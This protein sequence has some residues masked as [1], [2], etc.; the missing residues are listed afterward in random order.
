[1]KDR[2][3]YGSTRST[4][5]EGPYEPETG[6]YGDTIASSAD[7]ILESLVGAMF[8]AVVYLDDSLYIK[9]DSSRL[10]AFIEDGLSESIEGKPFIDLISDPDD[11][12]R[13][14][15]F[16][17]AISGTTASQIELSLVGSNCRLYI[18]RT[19]AGSSNLFVGIQVL[20]TPPAPPA[21]PPR[22]APTVF[23]Q[24]YRTPSLIEAVES[25]YGGYNSNCRQFPGVS[26][27][28]D[29]APPP[30]VSL[31]AVFYR[32][33][34]ND[35]VHMA[36]SAELESH[37]KAEVG[38]LT[39]HYQPP[40]IDALVEDLVRLL[41]N[42]KQLEFLEAVTRHDMFQVCSL[43]QQT[44]LG[45]LNMLSFSSGL[46]PTSSVQHV[47]AASRLILGHL[48]QMEET[49]LIPFFDKWI[50]GYDS[51][52]MFC[53]SMRAKIGLTM[54]SC[55]IRHPV[56][57][58]SPEERQ[59]LS[60][61]FS[62]LIST[63][64]SFGITDSVR[65]LAVYSACMLWARYQLDQGPQGSATASNLLEACMK[66]MDIFS[67]RHPGSV[68]VPKLRAMACFN[69][70]SVALNQRDFEKASVW[71]SEL[72]SISEKNFE[73]K[74]AF[75]LSKF[76]TYPMILSAKKTAKESDKLPVFMTDY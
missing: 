7:F 65:L 76:D 8:D 37:P 18:S 58:D 38:W 30:S 66:D 71:V 47:C 20:G 75:W 68:L 6:S 2:E 70:A 4:I 9:A 32:A 49:A 57:F 56:I 13:F 52:N 45:N 31:V 35:L 36:S 27:G 24:E 22:L 33:L 59:R 63:T 62:K 41:P 12:E 73:E 17:S 53:S 3:S 14:L 34:N 64:D 25:T 19:H 15:R 61:I 48:P 50:N 74:H 42:N 39:Q 28:T 16:M 40:D 54:I 60:G 44:T 46:S 69:L 43:L 10:R 5:S 29:P 11:A 55:A 23:Q 72:R 21:I 26:Y 51:L 1:M 67:L